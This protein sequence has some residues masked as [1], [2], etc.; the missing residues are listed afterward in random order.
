MVAENTAELLKD[1]RQS[2][3]VGLRL[4]L[5]GVVLRLDLAA[6]SEGQQTQIFITYPWSMFSVDNPG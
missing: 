4:L 1:G 3:G 6:G 2:Y 5:S